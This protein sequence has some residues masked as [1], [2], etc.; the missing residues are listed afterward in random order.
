MKSY[1]RNIV[2]AVRVVLDQNKDSAPLAAVGDIDT[3]S[4]DEIIEES[5]PGAIRAVLLTAPDTFFDGGI[6]AT[7]EALKMKKHAV[8]NNVYGYVSVELPADFIRLLSMKMSD[9][10]FA[11]SYAF[12]RGDAAYAI[13]H[14]RVTSLHGNAQ[15]PVAVVTPDGKHIE[16]FSSKEDARLDEFVYVGMPS[17]VEEGSDKAVEI[18]GK[19]YPS[20]VY[21]CASLVCATL[22]DLDKSNTMRTIALQYLTLNDSE[23]E[24][25]V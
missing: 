2:R 11:V 25:A 18:G 4:I 3:L 15:R 5:I 7:S 24:A 23:R 1:Y 22:G 19:M 20:V 14:S 10:D 6:S 13:Q 21:Y 9:W 8:A 16:A 12:P 17:V